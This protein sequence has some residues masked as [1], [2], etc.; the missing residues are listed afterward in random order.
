MCRARKY[1][2][3]F[4]IDLQQ[5]DLYND[6]IFRSRKNRLGWSVRGFAKKYDL[7]NPIGGNYYFAQYDEFVLILRSRFTA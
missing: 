6:M 4:L 3:D 2:N 1:S 5:K 7:G